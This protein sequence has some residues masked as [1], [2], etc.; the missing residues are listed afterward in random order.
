MEI[1]STD[2]LIQTALKGNQSAF[3][4]LL[5]MYWADV[6]GFLASKKLSE[7]DTED[8]CIE[9]FTKAFEKLSTYNPQYQFKTWLINIAKHHYVD[10]RRA[11]AHLFALFSQKI[12]DSQD[13]D[14]D[15][16]S[17]DTP[18]SMMIDIQSLEHFN[19]VVEYLNPRYRQIIRLRYME[20]MSIE[21]ISEQMGISE[22]HTK[23][24]LM[25]ARRMLQKG[26]E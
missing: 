22:S 1:K 2:E 9:T 5:G 16:I 13:P 7:E 17:H 25:R 24:M 10:F 4:Q 20:D 8:L 11:N 6:Y 15:I 21:E 19:T 26:L 14:V 12:Q 23:V 3:A 18:E